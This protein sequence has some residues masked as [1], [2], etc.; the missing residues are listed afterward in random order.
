[1]R[2][3]LHFQPTVFAKVYII[4]TNGREVLCFNKKFMD[5]MENKFSL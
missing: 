3:V 5:G 4:A 2:Q 1:M